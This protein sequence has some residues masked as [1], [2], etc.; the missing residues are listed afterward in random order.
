MLQK[1]FKLKIYNIIYVLLQ[2]IITIILIAIISH[3]KKI[4]GWSNDILSNIQKFLFIDRTVLSK[5]TMMIL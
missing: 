4:R 5:T 2:I 1:L 3:C